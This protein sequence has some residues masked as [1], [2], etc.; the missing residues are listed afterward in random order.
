MLE[1]TAG[2]AGYAG[3]AA[4]PGALI[5][6]ASSQ[7]RQRPLRNS[8][9]RSRSLRSA[10]S[11]RW[12]ARHPMSSFSD[13]PANAPPPAWPPGKANLSGTASASWSGGT[14]MS[15]SAEEALFVTHLPR[16]FKTPAP[17]IVEA[18][19]PPRRW[20]MAFSASTCSQRLRS[21][22]T[23]SLSVPPSP[24]SAKASYASA[25]SSCSCTARVLCCSSTSCS[26]RLTQARLCRAS[27]RLAVSSARKPSNNKGLTVESSVVAASA[28]GSSWSS[29]LRVDFLSS[30]S[31][32]S[33][34]M[35]SFLSASSSTRRWS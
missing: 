30:A 16:S 1:P 24:K 3:G 31:F 11:L 28:S 14:P 18:K 15:A 29:T 5:A 35:L 2:A 17:A 4:A 6:S 25:S 12:R 10:I 8:S 26:R 27:A 9:L 7:A 13:S 20:S 19:M 23:S 21:H 33:S 22:A 32:S 34:R